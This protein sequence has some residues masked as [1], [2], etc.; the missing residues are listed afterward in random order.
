MTERKDL[1]TIK[2]DPKTLLPITDKKWPTAEKLREIAKTEEKPMKTRR[3]LSPHHHIKIKIDGSVPKAFRTNIGLTIEE[4][5]VAI[6]EGEKMI[7]DDLEK[8]KK[9]RMN[10]MP[11]E[12]I[13]QG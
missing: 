7:R 12:I 2:F 8:L 4:A 13:Y 5:Q 10:R 11:N 9:T 6:Q 1:D 3:R